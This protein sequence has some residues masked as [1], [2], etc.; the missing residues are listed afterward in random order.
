[1]PSENRAQTELDEVRKHL[2]RTST[3]NGGLQGSFRGDQETYNDAHF[4]E[5]QRDDYQRAKTTSGG[6]ALDRGPAKQTT[7]K[8]AGIGTHSRAGGLDSKGEKKKQLVGQHYVRQND[9][10]QEPG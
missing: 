10:G 9:K 2:Q 4:C 1:M 3:E 8:I 5:R 6:P 7:F